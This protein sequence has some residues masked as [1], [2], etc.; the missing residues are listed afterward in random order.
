LKLTLQ[1]S[2]LSDPDT[3]DNHTASQ[4]IIRRLSDDV[5]VLDSGEDNANKTSRTVADGLLANSATYGWQVRYKDNHGLWSGYSPQTTFTTIAP[6]LT[7]L[8]AGTNLVL[9]WPTSALGFSLV[10]MNNLNTS[11]WTLVSLYRNR[12]RSEHGYEPRRQR[13]KVLAVRRCWR[14]QGR[15]LGQTGFPSF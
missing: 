1:A 6:D 5:T 3:G 14:S 13:I 4:W 12:Q 11:N 9:S 15:N 2:P 10:Y 7:A 8:R